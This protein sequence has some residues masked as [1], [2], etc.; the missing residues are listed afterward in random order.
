MS[1]KM[2]FLFSWLCG[3]I[4]ASC[5]TA[6]YYIHQPTLPDRYGTRLID[7]LHD[8]GIDTFFCYRKGCRGCDELPTTT[9][10][11]SALKSTLPCLYLIWKD[12]GRAF[13][14]KID[15]YAVYQTCPLYGGTALFM[16]FLN[17]FKTEIQTEQNEEHQAQPATRY[18]FYSLLL[19]TGGDRNKTIFLLPESL[20]RCPKSFLLVSALEFQLQEMEPY[21]RETYYSYRLKPRSKKI[22][23][24]GSL[25]LY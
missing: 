11:P 6:Q 3:L 22:F 5:I 1:W 8:R 15:G 14:K 13:V 9:I 17:D 16:S 19:H 7:S 10:R 23:N 25:S 24:K 12:S 21:F 20:S 2:R 18:V 4:A